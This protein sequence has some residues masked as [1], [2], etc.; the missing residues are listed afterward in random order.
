MDGGDLNKKNPDT[1]LNH[2]KPFR[3]KTPFYL[4]LY[5][6]FR[7]TKPTTTMN[8]LVACVFLLFAVALSVHQVEGN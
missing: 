1:T 5:L 2:F 4:F 8:K 7:Q 3:L 6:F